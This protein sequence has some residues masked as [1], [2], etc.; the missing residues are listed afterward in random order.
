MGYAFRYLSVERQEQQP[1]Q[2]DR[3]FW[4]LL[5]AVVSILHI[6]F[7][8]LPVITGLDMIDHASVPALVASK[9]ISPLSSIIGFPVSYVLIP[10][11]VLIV[12]ILLISSSIRSSIFHGIQRISSR[13][14]DRLWLLFFGL[15]LITAA[16]VYTVK[17]T[18]LPDR[19][20]DIE[21]IFRYQPI[22]KLMLI[23]LY[24]LFGIQEWVGRVLQL[25]LFYGGAYYIYQTARLFGSI[26]A[27]RLSAIVFLLLPPIFHYGNTHLIEGGSLFFV[28]ATFF[29]WI[30][31]WEKGDSYDLMTGSFM[32]TMGCLYKHTNVIV[33]PAFAVMWVWNALREGTSKPLSQYGKEILANTIPTVTFYLYLKLSSFSSDTPS[34][35]VMPN[36]SRFTDN[37]EAIPQGVT[38]AVF[39]AFLA[40]SIF[41]M[42]SRS[43][44]LPYWISWVIPHMILTVMSMAYFNVRQA[45]PYYLGLIVAAA[46]FLDRIIP[47]QR[48]LRYCLFYG[49]IPA[50]LIWVCLWMPREHT[51]Y[52]W[53][54]AMGDRSYINF[55]NWESTYVPY[56]IIIP[57]LM[58]RTKPEEKVFAPMGNDTSQFYL[59]KHNW[60]KRIYERH[61]FTDDGNVVFESLE[62]LREICLEQGYDLLLLP[63]GK[64]LLQYA[65][66][67]AVEPLFENPPD[68]VQHV[69]TYRYGTVEV[70]LWKVVK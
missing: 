41:V 5:F 68:W 62:R 23:P 42:F 35:I 58:E 32:A 70:G 30:R 60:S 65:D 6:P 25:I 19:F 64:W 49:L 67:Q 2:H 57:D 48:T 66:P 56:H 39:I 29:Y 11:M 15:I 69:Q 4:I 12:F 51:P 54:R 33:I 44:F 55:S 43:R 9:V 26:H 27:A 53:G 34:K 31:Y 17:V 10:L 20:G 61:L 40:G 47:P 63:R 59:A 8:N 18:A 21:T 7:L 14:F 52:E 13:C 24:I 45:L 50:Y 1:T 22:S 37:I 3:W 46:L 38:Y 36:W 28:L 16:Y